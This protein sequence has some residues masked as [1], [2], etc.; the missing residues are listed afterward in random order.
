MEPRRIIG[1]IMSHG[2]DQLGN[3]SGEA[4][5]KGADAAVVNE[6]AGMA[7]ERAEGDVVGGV[8]G[9]GEVFGELGEVASDEDAGKIEFGQGCGGGGE[10]GV[11]LD[12]RAAGGEDDRFGVLVAS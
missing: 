12:I 4:L 7:K 3:S 2:H 8:D 5:A 10:E 9:L 6:G 11:C 1:L